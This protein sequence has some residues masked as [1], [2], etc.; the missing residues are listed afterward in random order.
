[1]GPR[2]FNTV[3]AKTRHRSCS[4]RNKSCPHTFD[5]ATTLILSSHLCPA[6]LNVSTI[7]V[8]RSNFSNTCYMLRLSHPPVFHQPSNTPGEQQWRTEGG[9]LG[10]S[11]PPLPEI[12]KISVESS[13]AVSISFCSSVC[14]HT[15]VIY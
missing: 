7:Q 6:F 8:F 13:S 14:S 5:L 10:G 12:P 11:T 4:R 2:R 3:L 9:G 15:V 1:M